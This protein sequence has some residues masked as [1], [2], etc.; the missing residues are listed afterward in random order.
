MS[1]RDRNATYPAENQRQEG[2]RDMTLGL[3]FWILM[4]IWL[5]FGI[6]L[7]LT[8]Y[9]HPYAVVGGN[10]LIFILFLL[11]GWKTFGAPLHG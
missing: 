2:A 3:A 7:P 10:L 1:P 6:V 5:V 4:L 11:V 9:G 8:P